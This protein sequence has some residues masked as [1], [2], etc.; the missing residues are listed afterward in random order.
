MPQDDPAQAVVLGGVYSMHSAP[1]SKTTGNR[2]GC[3]TLHTRDGQ[4]IQLDDTRHAIR[5]EDRQGNL[6][7]L[8]PEGMQIHAAVDLDIAAP[9]RRVTIRAA[10]ID[11]ERA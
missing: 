10:R 1:E 8:A 5:L 3:Y 6:V 7:D 2:V 4:T 11:F 9:G